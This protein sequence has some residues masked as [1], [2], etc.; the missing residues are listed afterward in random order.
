MDCQITVFDARPT[1]AWAP[2]MDDPE[3]R[4]EDYSGTWTLV[5]TGSATVELVD[6]VGITLGKPSYEES[7]NTLTQ[8]IVFAKGGYDTPLS[9]LSTIRRT[10]ACMHT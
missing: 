2:P 1:H 5:L 8:P 7:T 9:C 4:Q 6:P 3:H 10:C